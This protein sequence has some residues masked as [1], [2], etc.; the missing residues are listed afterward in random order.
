MEMFFRM[1]KMDFNLIIILKLKKIV[2][3]LDI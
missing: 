2:I 3:S 1:E